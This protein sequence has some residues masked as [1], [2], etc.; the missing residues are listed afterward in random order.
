MPDFEEIYQKTPDKMDEGEYR[1]AVFGYLH[2]FKKELERINDRLDV[3]NGKVRI[4]PE[5]QLEIETQCT[6]IRWVWV[7]LSA[8][9]FAILIALIKFI[10]GF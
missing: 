4:I 1:L 7:I 3:T 2:G 6:K 5:M 10:I 8:L 9:G